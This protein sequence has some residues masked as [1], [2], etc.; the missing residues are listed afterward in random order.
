MTGWLTYTLSIYHTLNKVVLVL[1]LNIQFGLEI[2]IK[3][4]SKVCPYEQIQNN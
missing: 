2:E 3:G 1:N 4:C